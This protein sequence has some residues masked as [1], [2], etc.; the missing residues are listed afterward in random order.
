MSHDVRTEAEQPW[1]FGTKD[2]AIVYKEKIN[3]YVELRIRGHHAQM[4]MGR[5]FGA[6]NAAQMNDATHQRIF[7]LESNP[8]YIER[9]DA[10]LKDIKMDEL[11]SPKLAIHEMLSIL[12][13]PY[14][15]DNT[16]L[17]AA[18]ELNIV[19]GITVVDENGKTKAG[20]SLADFYKN[21][22]EP[23]SDDGSREDR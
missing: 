4:A 14:T 15:K 5:V 1:V 2:F 6:E 11:W 10:R 12:R 23:P 22:H 3:Q 17:A 13:S 8:Y 9:F 21:V 16:Q 20:R 7:Y 19:F 18:K